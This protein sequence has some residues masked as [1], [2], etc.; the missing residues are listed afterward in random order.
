MINMNGLCMLKVQKF[1]DMPT[2]ALTD[3]EKLTSLLWKLQSMSRMDFK[4]KVSFIHNQTLFNAYL[5]IHIHR[6]IILGIGSILYR[7]ILDRTARNGF[8]TAIA[9]E[10]HNL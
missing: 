1:L 9:G 3:L 2:L 7:E 6:I 5:F 8:K 10:L 4:G